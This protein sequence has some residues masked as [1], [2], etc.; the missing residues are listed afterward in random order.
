[1]DVDGT[2]AEAGAPAML[3]VHGFN[4][5]P[6]DMRE[7]EE[8]AR[9][10]GFATRNLLLPGHGTTARDLARTTWADWAGA[11]FAATAELRQ[12]HR[13]V[14]L[15]GHSMGGALAL[16]VAAHDRAVA[17]VAALCPPLH[18]HPGEV[19]LAALGRRVVP[20]VPTLR[21]DIR[22]RE[23]RLRYRQSAYRWTPVAAAH[24]LFRALPGLER[25]LAAV[26]CPALVV[27]ARRDHVVPMRDGIETYQRLGTAEK[28]LLVLARSY[29]VVTK[30]VER[31]VVFQRVGD[32]ATRVTPSPEVAQPRG[33]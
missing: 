3:L 6:L 23:A 29:H 16:H 22:D 33:A 24:H 27:C 8:H 28:E 21:E 32:F 31:E 11:V 15:V 19:R 12:R 20:Y 5:H 2:R 30:D 4:G 9:A 7:L 18:M 17:G 26:R 13:R 1:M 10:L 14:V 25:E